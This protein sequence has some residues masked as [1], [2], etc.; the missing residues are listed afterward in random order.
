MAAELDGVTTEVRP[1][2]PEY[3]QLETFFR[4]ATLEWG[5]AQ[6]KPDGAKPSQ[7]RAKKSEQGS[8][9][10][11]KPGVRADRDSREHMQ[12]PS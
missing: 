2:P 5:E 10:L 1:S 12:P 6:A 3:W 4:R 8:A 11:C 7:L 9:V